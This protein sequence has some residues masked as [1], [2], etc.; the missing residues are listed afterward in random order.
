MFTKGTQNF[1]FKNVDLSVIY[2]I[3][4][5]SGLPDIYEALQEDIVRPS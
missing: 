3:N 4:V 5:L 1:H 2:I